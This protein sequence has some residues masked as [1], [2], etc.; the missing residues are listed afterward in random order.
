MAQ[1]PLLTE[2]GEEEQPYQKLRYDE[3]CREG[4]GYRE[5]C[6]A[7]LEREFLE[8]RTG[9]DSMRLLLN[10]RVAHEELVSLAL[11]VP[12]IIAE[13]PLFEA[14]KVRRSHD[15]ALEEAHAEWYG[16]ETPTNEERKREHR[17]R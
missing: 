16:W 12:T 11:Y 9:S 1:S 6:K 17:Q 2:M 5:F 3:L 8:L 15:L 10:R 4:Q 14:C 7:S 13:D